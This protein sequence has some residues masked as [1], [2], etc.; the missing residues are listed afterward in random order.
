MNDYWRGM[1]Q[2]SK[3]ICTVLVGT[4]LVIYVHASR[5]VKLKAQKTTFASGSERAKAPEYN[6][7]TWCGD[8]KG[9][10]SLTCIPKIYGPYIIYYYISKGSFIGLIGI[11]HS[12]IKIQAKL[13]LLHFY[14]CVQYQDR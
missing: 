12:S 2:S 8:S 9:L 7:G 10:H 13:I 6:I 14:Y 5:T 11:V 3:T 1:L 4:A